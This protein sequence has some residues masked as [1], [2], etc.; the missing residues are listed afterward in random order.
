[1]RRRFWLGLGWQ[2]SGTQIL[3]NKPQS[4]LDV[5]MV[6]AQNYDVYR[7][8]CGGRQAMGCAKRVAWNLRRL[9]GS[10]GIS[11]VALAAQAEVDRSYLSR[12]ERAV[13][14]PT[15]NILDRLADKLSSDISEFFKMPHPGDELP[16]MPKSRK[17]LPGPFRQDSRS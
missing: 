16:K 3:M 10:I 5:A 6:K 4:S 13:E 8:F 2:T 9:R 15:I 17:K 7:K 11:Q 14:N 1:M 12:L